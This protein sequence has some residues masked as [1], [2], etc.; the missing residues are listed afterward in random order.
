MIRA[1]QQRKH[2]AIRRGQRGARMITYG[3]E[4]RSMSDWAKHLGVC[5]KTLSVRINELG[6]PI[7]KALRNPSGTTLRGVK[8]GE[9]YL[10]HG[11][12][13]ISSDGI[14]RSEHVQIVE[15]VLGRSLPKGA[16]IHHVNEKRNDNRNCNLVVCPSSAYHRLLHQRTRAYNACGHANWLKCKICKQYS[17]PDQIIT[18]KDAG[19]FH[20]DCFNRY[21]RESYHRRKRQT[22]T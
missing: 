1:R 4:T 11:Y 3:G 9:G 22:S 6:W 7:S 21:N 10:R 16:E 8:Y 13:V 14:Q 5:R 17:A 18:R 19:N 20:R 12:V 15:R 2:P